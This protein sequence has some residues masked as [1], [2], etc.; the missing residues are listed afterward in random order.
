MKVSKVSLPGIYHVYL[1][2]YVVITFSRLGIKA[3]LPNPACGQ[4][5]RENDFFSILARA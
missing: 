4:L 1:S 5:N 3:W 2:T